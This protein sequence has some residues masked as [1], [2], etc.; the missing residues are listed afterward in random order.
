MG[1]E[2]TNA[3]FI[4]VSYHVAA[5]GLFLILGTLSGVL[6]A[7]KLSKSVKEDSEKRRKLM[8]AQHTHA[9]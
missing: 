1:H 8:K 2:S 9:T 4:P 7:G 5:V 3:L 6:I